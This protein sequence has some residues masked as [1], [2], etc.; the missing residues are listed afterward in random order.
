MIESTSSPTSPFNV[1]NLTTDATVYPP[2]KSSSDEPE[3]KKRKLEGSNGTAAHT[4]TAATDGARYTNQMLTNTHVTK[5]FAILKKECEDLATAIVS[6][7]A[8]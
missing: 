8:E 5:A 2:P 3:S 4:N 6:F 7:G 1:T